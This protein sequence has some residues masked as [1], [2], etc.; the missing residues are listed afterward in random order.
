[1]FG[2]YDLLIVQDGA[3]LGPSDFVKI[4]A[5]P[6]VT[7][8]IEYVCNKWASPTGKTKRQSFS[9]AAL[10]K[11]LVAVCF[12]K[13]N[14]ELTQRL[15][16][17]P[18]LTF[19]SYIKRHLPSVQLLSTLGWAEVVLL[20]SENSLD[21][22]LDAIG[23][24]IPR[25]IFQ[26][27]GSRPSAWSRS[28]AEKT[29]TMIGHSLD[30]STHTRERRKK[31]IVP[32]GRKLDKALRISFS[33]ACR[34]RSTAALERSAVRYF[35]DCEARSRLGAR[36]LEFEVP[37][38]G[39]DT[40]NTLLEKIDGF[41][42]DNSQLLIRAHTAFKYRKQRIPGQSSL[43]VGR[44]RR[45]LSVRL[46]Q[47]QARQLFKAGPEATSIATAIYQFN[48][49]IQNDVSFD[50]YLDLSRSIIALRNEML[51]RVSNSSHPPRLD[52][53]FLRA[54]ANKL[55]HL[56]LAL[57]QR[58]Q[59]VYAGIEENPFGVY[60]TGIGLQ[61]VVK[62]L[63][64]YA[65]TVLSRY[66]L[67]WDGFVRFGHLSSRMEHFTDILIVP[68]DVS[69]YARRHWTFTHEVMHVLQTIAPNTL[70]TSSLVRL[71]ARGKDLPS[72]GYEPGTEGWYVLL[73]SMMDVLDFALCCP[74]SLDGYLQTVWQ[75]LEAEIFSQQA[76]SQWSVYLW[77]SF[78]V[79]LYAHYGHSKDMER[80][81]FD[82]NGMLSLLEK[83]TKKVGR[84]ANLGALHKKNE[85]GERDVTLICEQFVNEFV[86]YLP[87]MFQKVNSLATTSI[88]ASKRIGYKGAI[89]RLK[90]GQILRPG[91]LGNIDRL[92]WHI[93]VEGNN[94]PRFNLAWLLSLWH[95]YQT[96]NLGLNPFSAMY[97]GAQE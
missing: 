79:I 6:S 19:A 90:A 93:A 7:G 27:A 73:E 45:R 16:L 11:P 14:P 33:V 77:R 84:W 66:Q 69:V 54:T 36:D 64:A 40:L 8:S 50:V 47:P 86:F 34:P 13:I 21:G 35:G 24:H 71:D 1:M 57:V 58:S 48:N 23:T 53:A 65:T 9:L 51:Q 72:S 5:L 55:S 37:V 29:L 28:F 56:E 38:Q 18:E 39:T 94:T 61:R 26:Y 3:E 89:R 60:P 85:R 67:P 76:R 80:R 46:T 75:F 25:L 83:Y 70:S 20:I 59:S 12:L 43:N 97:N 22:I 62:A 49:L 78:A 2:T 91:D 74:L 92:A 41:T 30:V 87:S 32:I 82:R 31:I 63:E 81:L 88:N 96:S 52:T 10:S 68:M 17:L 42:R 44:P 15:G 4:G 95:Y